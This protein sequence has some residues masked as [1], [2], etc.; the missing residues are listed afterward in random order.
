MGVR[1]GGREVP[2]D[3]EAVARAFPDATP[4]VALF[5]HG[6][7]E[8]EAGWHLAAERHYGDADSWHGSRLRDDLGFTP[9]T[10]RVNTGL[11]VSDNGRRLAELL[12]RLDGCWPVPV[13]EILLVGHS[14][15]GLINRS[16]CHYGMEDGRRPGSS[17]CATS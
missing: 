16:A 4:R 8:S 11:R 15:G 6:L 7:C 17:A 10:L 1:E 5:T 14:M 13:E 12:D 3:S 2:M 9:V